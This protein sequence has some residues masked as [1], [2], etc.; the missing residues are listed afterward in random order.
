MIFLDPSIK[1]RVTDLSHGLTPSTLNPDICITCPLT[2]YCGSHN[3]YGIENGEQPQLTPEEWIMQYVFG[4]TEELEKDN[5]DDLLRTL[6]DPNHYL[7]CPGAQYPELIEKFRQSEEIKPIIARLEIDRQ[8]RNRYTR[9]SSLISKAYIS[10]INLKDLDFQNTGAPEFEKLSQEERTLLREEFLNQ[11]IKR[12]FVEQQSPDSG[13]DKEPIWD[14]MYQQ[15]QNLYW[16]I[17]Q[18]TSLDRQSSGEYHAQKVVSAIMNDCKQF[19]SCEY[20]S[21]TEMVTYNWSLYVAFQNFIENMEISSAQIE[22]YSRNDKVKTLVKSNRVKQIANKLRRTFKDRNI[23]FDWSQVLPQ[24][25]QAF[26]SY[27]SIYDNNNTPVVDLHSEDEATNIKMALQGINLIHLPQPEQYL[28][29]QRKLKQKLGA[30][31]AI[32]GEDIQLCIAAFSG[33]VQ[34]FEAAQA[35]EGDL[36]KR[37]NTAVLADKKGIFN[38]ENIDLKR[39]PLIVDVNISSGKT[40]R[41]I[42]TRLFKLGQTEALVYVAAPLKDHGK[43]KMEGYSVVNLDEED[44]LFLIEKENKK[45]I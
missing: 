4:P 45:L 25:Q 30:A 27:I 15:S 24:L 41:N 28:I 7:L 29:E 17:R 22:E 26:E 31:R 23:K 39:T 18:N 10:G 8:K 40:V 37:L 38:P 19:W 13:E 14:A 11:V 20:S 16:L 34:G 9:I 43:L 12:K 32:F 36:E 6:T 5:L 3:L 35:L 44:R 21:I 42:M 33:T 2:E 1:A